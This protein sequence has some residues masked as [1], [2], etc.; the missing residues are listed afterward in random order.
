[1]RFVRVIAVGATLIAACAKPERFD[2]RREAPRPTASQPSSGAVQLPSGRTIADVAAK[3]T[4]AVVNVFSERTG[5]RA[6]GDPVFERFLGRG[7]REQRQRGLGSGVIVGTDGVVLTNNH[8]IDEADKIR[9]ALQDGRELEAKVVGKDPDSDLAVLHVDAKRLPTIE[10]ADSSQVRIGDLVLAVGN[11][12]GIGQTVTMGIIS[13]L[14]RADIGILDLEDFIQTDAAINPGNS[15]GAL[16][17]MN[18]RLVGINTAIASRSGGYQ[19]IGFAIPS[20][21]A[22]K[23]KDEI[24]EHGKVSRGYLGVAVKDITPELARTLDLGSPRGV[25]VA[26]VSPKSPAERAG[27]AR[28]D[29]ILSVDGKPATSAGQLRTAIALAGVDHSV[30][31]EVERAGK[32]RTLDIMLGETPTSK[33]ASTGPRPNPIVGASVQAVDPALRSRLSI[34]PTLQGG[35]VVTH[36]D[37]ASPAANLGLRQG[38]IVFEVNHKPVRDAASFRQAAGSG[39]RALMLVYRDGATQYLTR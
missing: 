26:E 37:P 32:K 39:D 17:D 16:V 6:D 13:A 24:L 15:G 4:P 19:G 33:A 30:T 20:N 28:G 8:L 31:L 3:V 9:V 34:P 7:E 11:P 1:M 5:A 35:V 14:G 12:F 23:I 38:D 2:D 36:V 10:I 27:L 18:G 29:V 21:M 22:L 25:L